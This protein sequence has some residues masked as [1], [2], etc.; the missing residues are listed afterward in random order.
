LD[1]AVSSRFELRRRTQVDF[2]HPGRGEDDEQVAQ[3]IGHR[4]DPRF[5]V[6]ARTVLHLDAPDHEHPHERGER[7]QDAEAEAD[8][9]VRVLFEPHV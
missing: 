5:R 7:M 3:P 6:E 4:V 9:S 2:T 8:A 1:A